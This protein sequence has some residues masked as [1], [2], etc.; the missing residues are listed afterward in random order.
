MGALMEICDT[1]VDA[2][3]DSVEVVQESCVVNSARNKKQA[4]RLP[5]TLWVY[6]KKVQT[7]AL[8]D[9]GATTNFIDYKFVSENNLVTNKLATPYEVRNADGTSNKAGNITHAVRAY[10]EIETHKHTQY[11]LVTNLGDK[12]MYIGYQFLHRHNPEID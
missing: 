8:V 4:F 1:I 3:Q 12:D 6:G 9:S 7:E 10:I 2:E 11:L 5:V